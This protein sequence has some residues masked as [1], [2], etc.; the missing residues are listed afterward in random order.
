MEI[1][2]CYLNEGFIDEASHILSEIPPHTQE[3]KR[4]HILMAEAYFN[5]HDIASSL[6]EMDMA[7]DDDPYDVNSWSMLAEIHYESKHT[8][9]CQD[10]CQYALAIDAKNEKALRISFFA[11]YAVHNHTKALETA[12]QYVSHWPDEYYIPMNAGELCMHEGMMMEALDYLGRA[13]RNCPADHQDHLRIITLVAGIKAQQGYFEES[14]EVLKCACAYVSQYSMVCVQ[15]ASLAM[16]LNNIPFASDC[17]NQIIG[18]IVPSNGEL[19]AAVRD[20]FNNY[21]MLYLACP[22]VA[23]ALRQINTSIS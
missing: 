11:Y 6:K 3:S 23:K 19:C 14:F 4:A 7:I 12:Q 5:R 22:D 15:M 10:A 2:E 20:L 21:Q 16:E 8:A 18:E 17:L 1:A 9:E 13:N